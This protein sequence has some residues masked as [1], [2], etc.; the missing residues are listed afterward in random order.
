MYRAVV[1][2][3][4]GERVVDRYEVPFG[5]REARFEAATGFWLN[6]ENI[7]LKGVC[8]HHDAG[9]L[10]AAVP[11]SVWRKRL[12]TLKRYGVNAV[13]TSHNPVAPEFLD[14]CDEMGV[15]VMDEAF[16]AWRRG[17]VPH[18]YSDLYEEHHVRDVTDMVRRDRNHPSVVIYSAGNEIHDVLYDPPLGVAVFRELVE[19]FHRADPTRPVTVAVNQPERSRIHETGFVEM[20]DVAGYNYREQY[21]VDGRKA[22]P[23]RKIIGTENAKS[24]TAWRV[25]RD[26]PDL[27]GM[28]LWTGYDYLGESVRRWPYLTFEFGM[29]DFSGNPRP[30]AEQF[31]AYWTKEPVVS[32]A[33]LQGVTPLPSGTKVSADRLSDWNP[34]VRAGEVVNLEVYSNA[35][36][37]ELFLNGRSLGTRLVP[38]DASPI[39]WPTVYEPGEL[40]AV[41]K[42][43]ERGAAVCEARLRTSGR[44]E[45]VEVSVDRERL[46]V[47]RA[48]VVYV[49]AR[50][51]DAAG[52]TVT[53]GDV[54]VRFEAEGPGELLATESGDLKS[55]ESFQSARRNTFRG[56][57]TA[58][59]RATGP[60]RIRVRV[61]GEGVKGGAAEVEA[62]AGAVRELGAGR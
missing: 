2:L 32:V 16:D 36:A 7:K 60:G 49:S 22:A 46:P 28:F 17:K 13:R 5:I 51:V 53:D 61:S 35:A 41:G 31:R 47:D 50:L 29:F 18:D 11:V 10:G 1:E 48:E 40:R 58:I 27:A 30:V 15:V 37:V 57:C 21:S 23:G 52:V 12:E 14:L 8:L 6:G 39:K 44:A 45:R 59:Y 20:E 62:V 3:V 33:R 26:N 55:H 24:S 9:G 54:G 34:P 38:E 43:A 56:R 25:V 4:T 42:S 19:V